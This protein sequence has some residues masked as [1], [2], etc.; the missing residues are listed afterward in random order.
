MSAW[1]KYL[2]PIEESSHKYHDAKG[3]S[4]FGARKYGTQG[5]KYLEH[6]EESHNPLAKYGG[7]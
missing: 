5:G 7:T 3:K 6:I 4:L 1:P 2:A